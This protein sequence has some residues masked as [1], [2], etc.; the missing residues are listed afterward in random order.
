MLLW[1][2]EAEPALTQIDTWNAESNSH[3]IGIN[4]QL[5]YQI[6]ARAKVYQKKAD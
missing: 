6:V 3:M 1:L 2:R 4:E 5:G